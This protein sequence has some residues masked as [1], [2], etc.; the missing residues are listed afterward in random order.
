M[1]GFPKRYGT[2]FLKQMLIIILNRT[3][4]I[5]N[6]YWKSY[7]L[8]CGKCIGWLTSSAM[9]TKIKIII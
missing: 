1:I 6:C 7:G 4:K 3:I 2:E 9:F 8:G 5:N